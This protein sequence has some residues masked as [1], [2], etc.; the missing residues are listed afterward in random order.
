MSFASGRLKGA[1]VLISGVTGF[2]GGHLARQLNASGAR[3]YG[4]SRAVAPVFADGHCFV[5][6]I[7]DRER[8]NGIIREIRPSYVFHLAANKSRSALISDFRQCIDQNLIGTL[9]L[10]EAC[11]LASCDP[12][13]I[14]VGTCEE[15]GG[16]EAPYSETQRES[17]V[18]AYSCSK[19]AATQL[20]Q[21]FH[22]IHGLPVVVLRPTLAYGPGQGDGMFLPALIRS[23]LTGQRFAMSPGEQTRDYIYIDDVVAALLR[24]AVCPDATGQVINVSSGE[25]TRIVDVTRSVVELIGNEAED[26]L[27]IGKIAYRPG[28]AM[29]YWADRTRAKQLLGWEPEVTLQEG[30]A[31]T[32]EYYRA[33]YATQG[34]L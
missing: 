1:A 26:L 17:P 19:V 34:A 10:L 14:S 11:Q 12:R 28:E 32:V 24:A 27:D 18:S 8:L 5:C 29:N 7:Q 4:L 21:T 20:L 9:N 31:K 13:F 25:P 3:V 22:R 33:L 2:I 6:D 30:L 16:A 15:Y 23:L